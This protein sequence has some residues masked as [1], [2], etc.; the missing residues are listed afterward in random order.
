MKKAIALADSVS[1]PALKLLAALNALFFLSFLIV[2]L[3][4]VGRAQR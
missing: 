3:L 2:L 1:L 4:A